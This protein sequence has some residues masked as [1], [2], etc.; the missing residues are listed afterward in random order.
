MILLNF[1]K[2]CMKLRKFWAIGGHV[3][4]VAPL[5]LPLDSTTVYREA[6]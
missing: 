3:P 5:N 4:G 1:T 6:F 2:N